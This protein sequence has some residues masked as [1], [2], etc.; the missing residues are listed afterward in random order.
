MI[1]A[2]TDRTLFDELQKFGRRPLGPALEQEHTHRRIEI[3]NFGT[4]L[5]QLRA[6]HHAAPHIK[7]HAGTLET[8][9]RINSR[10]LRPAFSIVKRH[11]VRFK[12]DEKL[13]ML[14]VEKRIMCKITLEHKIH[15]ARHATDQ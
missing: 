12:R 15:V 13:S 7:H 10:D 1:D 2:F 4:R 5:R 9:I 8:Q 11:V 3:G 14:L 6:E